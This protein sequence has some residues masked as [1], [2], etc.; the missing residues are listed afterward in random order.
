M[1]NMNNRDDFPPK[2]KETLLKRVGNRCSNP[3]CQKLTTGPH[4]SPDDSVNT[5][6]AA[7]ITAAAPGGPRYNSNLTEKER[8]ATANG[9]WLCQNCAKLIDNDEKK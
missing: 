8:K 7:H 3:D 2:V 6:V 1:S 4:S 9:I 5:G